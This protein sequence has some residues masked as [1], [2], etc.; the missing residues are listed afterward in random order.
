MNLSRTSAKSFRR[1]PLRPQNDGWESAGMKIAG[2]ALFF[3]A[4]I[5]GGCNTAH[6]VAVTSFHVIDAPA[7]F[8]RRKIDESDRPSNANARSDVRNPGQPIAPSPTPA[9]RISEYTAQTSASPHASLKT[10]KTASA[11]P[12]PTPQHSDASSPKS[13]PSSPQTPASSLPQNPTARAVPG[14]PGYVF[15]PFDPSGGYVDVNG[16]PP[17]SKVKDPYSGKIFLVPWASNQKLSFLQVPARK[18]SLRAEKA[19]ISGRSARF[20]LYGNYEPPELIISAIAQSIV[21]D[22]TDRLQ[23]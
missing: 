4:L 11:K 12:S 1:Y 5:F 7:H 21:Q 15:S 17:G 2:R 23:N 19:E 6:D 3:S 22:Q 8:V 14:K 20:L 18:K 16:Y 9:R 13:L 10:S